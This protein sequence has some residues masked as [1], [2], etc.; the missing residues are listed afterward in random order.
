MGKAIQIAFQLLLHALGNGRDAEGGGIGDFPQRGK[1]AE[2]DGVKAPVG[3]DDRVPNLVAAA[4]QQI[5]GQPGLPQLR[6][7]LIA[8]R[9]QAE[10][11]LGEGL[12]PLPA[13]FQ[14]GIMKG[15]V[16]VVGGPA[17]GGG[18]LEDADVLIDKV[19]NGF[20]IP[21]QGGQ[22]PLGGRGLKNR[23]VMVEMIKGDKSRFQIDSSFLC[24]SLKPSGTSCSGGRSAGRVRCG[25]PVLAGSL[26]G[27]PERSIA[28]PVFRPADSREGRRRPRQSTGRRGCCRSPSRFAG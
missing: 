22:G 14:G 20:A 10:M 1:G 7:A 5:I 9:R 4:D 28:A 3:E 25:A 8:V 11:G 23:P 6:Q 21:A 12:K 24:A 27:G 2:E 19:V 13:P 18:R 26:L 15:V 17:G 16:G